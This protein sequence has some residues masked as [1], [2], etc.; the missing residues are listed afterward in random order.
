[1]KRKPAF[2]TQLLFKNFGSE[3][4]GMRKLL[5]KEIK[6]TAEKKVI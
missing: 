5:K 1:M 4:K 2:I 6:K 3:R